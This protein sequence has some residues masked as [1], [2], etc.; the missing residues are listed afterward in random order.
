MVVTNF[1]QVQSW[2]NY[3]SLPTLQV[4]TFHVLIFYKQRGQW[5]IRFLIYTSNA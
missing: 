4:I 5:P 2:V 3:L 1:K